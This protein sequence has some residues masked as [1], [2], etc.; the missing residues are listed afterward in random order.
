MKYQN[1][2]ELHAIRL[3]RYNNFIVFL[4]LKGRMVVDVRVK[5][6]FFQYQISSDSL[7]SRSRSSENKLEA[8]INGLYVFHYKK[9]NLVGIGFR[10]W[11]YFDKFKNCQ[12]L[13]IKLGLSRDVLIFVPLNIIVL[14]LRS[15]LILIKGI[16]KEEVSHMARYI[17]LIK[18]PDF[19]KGKGVRYENEIIRIKPGKQK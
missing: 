8:L 6:S 16:D 2:F 19:Y 3:F 11:V 10:A 17:K 4:S 7:I 15:T 12:V 9:L 5:K 14:C 1:S 18:S 13:S